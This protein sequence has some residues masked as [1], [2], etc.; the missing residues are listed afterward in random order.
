VTVVRAVGD[1]PDGLTTASF[2][3]PLYD[4]FA[5][6]TRPGARLSAGARALLAAIEEHMRAVADE[7]DRS[8]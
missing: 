3:P 2:R 5:V 6:V 7:L 4:T 8:R 1:C